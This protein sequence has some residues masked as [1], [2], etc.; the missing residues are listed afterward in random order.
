MH[1]LENDRWRSVFAYHPIDVAL[2]RA[3][4]I[5]LYDEDGQKYIDAS[6]GPM[7]VN[8]P[9]GHPA[10]KRALAEQLE[11][12]AY[13]HPH[14]ANP[15]KAKTCDALARVAPGDLNAAFLV[16]GG[17]EAVESAIKLARQYHLARGNAG[18]HKM[19][20][21]HE[22]YHGMTVAAM[23]L[24]GNPF[25]NRLFEPLMPRWPHVLQY[26][27]CDRPPSID[28]DEWGRTAARRLEQIILLEGPASV[29]A[30][31]ATPI[32]VGSEYGLFA[33]QSYWREV[34]RICDEHDVLLVADEVVT[35]FGR[36]GR[37]FCV[38]HHGIQPD[39]MTLAKGITSVAAP[40]GAVMVSDKVNAPFRDGVGF[41]HGFTNGGHPLGCAA[42]IALIDVLQE[43]KLVEN[44][45]A[46]GK[47]LFGY[48]DMLL[49]HPSIADVRGRGLLMVLELVES[50]ST[51]T[52]FGS[53]VNAELRFQNTA[54][55]NGLMF[56]ST[57]YGSRRSPIFSR[58]LPMW[59][60]PPLSIT[61]AEVDDLMQRLDRTLH[62]WE[63]ALG[64]T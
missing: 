10:I 11:R 49:G 59:I 36:T 60:S 29:A 46:V 20:G 52:F 25:Y 28:R 44:A 58:G 47:H 19:I 63:K 14:M 51:R 18:K 13:C 55:A 62:Q 7:A 37:W 42:A 23:A 6:G 17:S 64:I 38:E 22:S 40:L 8:L 57:L 61:R 21:M 39:I 16:S 50:K 31:F 33:P 45:E 9:H 4:G 53:K 30:F 15:L 1:S 43:E 5:Y 12:F 56:Y 48:R 2:A 54:L 3:E 41:V 26:S 32:G 35:G 24:A 27:D 34:R